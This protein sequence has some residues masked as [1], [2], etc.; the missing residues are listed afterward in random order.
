DGKVSV[1]EFTRYATEASG[2]R[3]NANLGAMI[4]RKFDAD[5][6]GDLTL[7]ELQNL[8]A[9]SGTPSTDPPPPPTVAVAAPPVGPQP[10]ATPAARPWKQGPQATLPSA[11]LDQLLDAGL[12]AEDRVAAAPLPDDQFLRRLTL[13]LTGKPPTAAE[14]DAF[15]A[16]TASDK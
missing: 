4:F 8:R 2:G 3:L 16:S 5:G 7:A 6:D 12:A 11:K 9:S 10:K 14:V 13:D 1:D 15:L